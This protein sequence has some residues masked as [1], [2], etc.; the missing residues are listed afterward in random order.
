MKIKLQTLRK[1]IR[2]SVD[3]PE[4]PGGDRLDALIKRYG[5]AFDAVGF[6]DHMIDL[7]DCDPEF[8]EAFGRFCEDWLT[9][10]PV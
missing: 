3:V 5:P 10:R 9:S 4:I 8:V 1:V 2:E 6:G 7:S